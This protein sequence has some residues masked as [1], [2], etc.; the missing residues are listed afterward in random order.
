MRNAFASHS[1]KLPI[2][3]SQRWVALARIDWKTGVSSPGDELIMRST[4]EVAV[5]CSRAS[6][7]SRL[8]A[9]S[10]FSSS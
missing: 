9:S 8:H 10:S 6:A 2:C 3:A 4:S 5:C 7:S 1:C